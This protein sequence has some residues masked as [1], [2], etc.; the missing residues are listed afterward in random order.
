M[1]DDDDIVQLAAVSKLKPCTHYEHRSMV[2]AQH[3]RDMRQIDYLED[4]IEELKQKIREKAI[5]T[6]VVSFLHGLPL[7]RRRKEHQLNP[8][9]KAIVDMHM[10][11][12]QVVQGRKKQ[13]DRGRQIESTTRVA[14]VG[15]EIQACSVRQ[16]LYP[17]GGGSGNRFIYYFH[18]FDSTTQRMR[19]RMA[20]GSK[21][22][23]LIHVL[24]QSGQLL[25]R[26][27][28]GDYDTLVD[29]SREPFLI[30]GRV[31][32]DLS[33]D[34]LL[35]VIYES[36]P[37]PLESKEEMNWLAKYSVSLTIRFCLDRAA[38]NYVFVSKLFI[39]VFG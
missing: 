18:E 31:L 2:H 10:A 7:D 11:A 22:Q 20:T 38:T 3:A 19:A 32:E 27:P 14:R 39:Q 25:V 16:N 33:P 4:V 28:N 17:D 15:R 35:S 36:M 23:D 21:G 37:L 12:Q 6:Q 30:N 29:A 26:E 24:M 5:E 8:V 13:V 1:D 9:Q 34:H